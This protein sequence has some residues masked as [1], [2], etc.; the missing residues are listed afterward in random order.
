MLFVHIFSTTI[1]DVDS[2]PPV[3]REM[4]SAVLPTKEA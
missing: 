4:D 3:V 1:P 2:G